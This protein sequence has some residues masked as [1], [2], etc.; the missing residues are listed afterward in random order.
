MPHPLRYFKLPKTSMEEMMR[1]WMA[2]RTKANERMKDPVVELKI[3]INQGLRNRQP[4]IENL[5]R[6]FEFLDKKTL[7]TKSLPQRKDD[8]EGWNGYGTGTPQRMEVE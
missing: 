6:Q 3:Q 8:K 4:I 1:E 5:E 2:K 7:R